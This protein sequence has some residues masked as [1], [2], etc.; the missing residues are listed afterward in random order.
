MQTIQMSDLYGQYLTMKEEIDAAIH[1]VIRSAQFVKSRKVREFEA[2]LEDYLETHVVSCG[3]GTDALQMALMALNLQPG[4]ELITTPFTFVSTVETAVLLG[5]KPVFVDVDPD[6]FTMDVAQ[7]EAVMSAKT[8]AIVPVHLFGQCADMETILTVA[9][10]HHLY[11][12]E[13]ACQALG[14]DYFFS[15][16]TSKKAGTMGHLGCNSFFPSKNLGAFG[17][18]GAVF[19]GDIALAE[20]IR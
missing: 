18:G 13:D 14:S 8:K 9:Q 15:D 16:G 1:D 19:T 10:K 4:D 2:A 12:V 20:T 11:V 17:D 6:T 7:I 3:N 5:L